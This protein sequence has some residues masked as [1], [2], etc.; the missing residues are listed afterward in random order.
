MNSFVDVL[1]NI[2]E[3]VPKPKLVHSLWYVVNDDTKCQLKVSHPD[4]FSDYADI[5]ARV[6][7]FYDNKVIYDTLISYSTDLPKF[8][9]KLSN[10]IKELTALNGGVS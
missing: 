3:T 1:K 10:K 7:L 5:I 2:K 6:T 4:P 8:C 9:E